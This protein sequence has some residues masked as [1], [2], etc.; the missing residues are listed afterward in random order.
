MC[1][2]LR[3]S[4]TPSSLQAKALASAPTDWCCV[5]RSCGGVYCDMCSRKEPRLELYSSQ[6]RVCD[7]CNSRIIE[8]RQ[9]AQAI[10]V[11]SEKIMKNSRLFAELRRKNKVIDNYLD[12]EPDRDAADE[13]GPGWFSLCAGEVRVPSRPTQLTFAIHGARREV[14]K[15]RTTMRLSK[16]GGR[17]QSRA[18]YSTWCNVSN[19]KL[20]GRG[21]GTQQ[22]AM[23]VCQ[24]RA[25]WMQVAIGQ[26]RGF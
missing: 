5:Y 16:Q 17:K 14:T 9:T 10:L 21:K 2:R 25:G 19:P 6:Q 3:L 23:F 4:L 7:G 11:K 22:S 15:T 20:V 12:E 24:L 1:H 26:I 18:V 13:P 8:I